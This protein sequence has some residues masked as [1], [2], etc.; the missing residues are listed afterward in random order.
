MF[1]KHRK[2]LTDQGKLNQ[3]AEHFEKSLQLKPASSDQT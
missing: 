2:F 1:D 3:A